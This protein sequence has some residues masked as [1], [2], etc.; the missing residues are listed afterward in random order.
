MDKTRVLIIFG[1]CSSEYEVSL[2]SA[3]SVVSN[4]DPN[5]YESI[6]IGITRDGKWSRYYG[7]IKKIARNLWHSDTDKCIP[8]LVSPDRSSHKLFELSV[9]GV[10][11]TSFDI[12]FPVLHGKNGEDGTVQGLLELAGIPIV[13]C[14]TLTSALCM[15]KDR[16]H[17]LIRQAGIRIPLSATF[18]K[19]IG[20]DKILSAARRL[21]YPLFVKPVKSGSSIGITKVYEEKQLPEAADNAFNF[22]DRIIIE[23][24]ISGFEVGCAV[25]GN[26]EL[27]IGE[28][29]EIE[30][31]A[32]F[33]N[34]EEKY[35]LKSSQIHMP[36]RLDRDI[37]IKIK[38]AA[39]KIYRILGCRGFARVDMFL[40]PDRKIIFNE[41]N[42]IPG[43][44]SHSRYPNMMKGIGLQFADIIDKLINLGLD[45]ENSHTGY[46]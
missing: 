40:T 44:T 20:I 15:D 18:S 5:K 42:T 32:D 23:E 22:D 30:I 10:R 12:A 11:E 39:A 29:D 26:E 6:L 16:A 41:V 25:L 2:Q 43:F 33:F 8:V 9:A 21:K 36:A 17:K 46:K 38:D 3:Y 28:L 35:T 31:D 34:Y 37:A 13:G 27:L 19:G 1:G 7:D 4:M 14:G 45:Y 24:N